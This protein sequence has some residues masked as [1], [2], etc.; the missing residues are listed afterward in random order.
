MWSNLKEILYPHSGTPDPEVMSNIFSFR[1]MGATFDGELFKE[2]ITLAS[3]VPQRHYTKFQEYYMPRC[4]TWRLVVRHIF[5]KE[6]VFGEIFD[7]E[8]KKLP[9]QQL[10]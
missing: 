2:K 1:T 6:G 4:C 7:N 8:H 5:D 10:S 3:K 9:S